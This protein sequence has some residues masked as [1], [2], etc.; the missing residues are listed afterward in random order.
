MKIWLLNPYGPLPGEAWRE[1][2]YAMLGRVLARHGHEVIWWTAGFCHHSKMVRTEVPKDIAVE[3]NFTIRLV[4]TPPYRRHIGLARLRFEFLFALRVLRMATRAGDVRAIVCSDATMTLGLVARFLARKVH[5]VLVYDILD[6][7]P[8]VFSG[9]LP[10]WL[11]P[12]AK[13]VFAPLFALRN[14]NFRHATG[15]AAV[16]D[17][18]LLP[19]RSA[20]P[21]FHEDQLLSVF[22]STDLECFD[23]AQASPEEIP[24]IARQ[25]GKNKSD[26][27]AI[28]AGTLGLLYDIDPLLE[29]AKRLQ[30]QMPELKL[31]V[32]G[33]GPRSADIKRFIT[34][35]NLNNLRLL[36][37]MSFTDLIRLYQICDIGMCIYGPNSP[38]AMP[39]KIFDYLAAGLPVINSIG[40]FLERLVRDR[41]L[42]MQY[43]AGDSAS[44]AGALCA[45]GSDIGALKRMSANARVA[46]AEFDSK[47]QY[48]RFMHL[49]ERL[50]GGSESHLRLFTNRDGGSEPGGHR[51]SA[52]Q[53]RSGVL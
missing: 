31:L 18:Y 33:G 24:Q 41:N 53:L 51:E 19:A 28:Y 30:T 16:C 4:P 43:R 20:N 8:E 44:L 13:T 35:N 39:I 52:P 23:A 32:A 11:R 37:E 29:A 21:S 47:L 26:I 22:W 34:N 1:T 3:P 42:G 27:Y 14:W 45:M 7:W 9:A 6:L 2:R 17:D 10:N 38:V 5:A 25:Y 12:R 36:G 15:V 50:S 48:G 49:L 40:G 46:R